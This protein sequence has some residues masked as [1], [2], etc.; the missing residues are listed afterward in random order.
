MPFFIEMKSLAII[1][2]F[3]ALAIGTNSVFAQESADIAK[4][5]NEIS[6]LNAKL[7]ATPVADESEKIFRQIASLLN[8]ISEIHFAKGEY[9]NATKF[10]LEA[11]AEIK[12][13]HRSYYDRTKI[14]LA[15]AE[16]KL[17][18]SFSYPSGI[19][20]RLASPVKFLSKNTPSDASSA[21]EAARISR[22]SV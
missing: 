14:E 12:K 15:N 13:Y 7:K 3:I 5:E 19:T 2:L 18:D 11:E 20:H 22:K 21:R 4:L 8:Q 10:S 17:K 9:E 6:L 1:L 16:N